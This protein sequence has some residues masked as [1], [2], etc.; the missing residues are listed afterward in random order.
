MERRN[1][2]CHAHFGREDRLF[3]YWIV[4]MAEQKFELGLFCPVD[5]YPDKDP[6][7]AVAQRI[8]ETVKIAMI[9]D[10]LQFDEM[11]IAEGHFGLATGVCTN[12]HILL[13]HLF[14]TT[15]NLKL[16]PGVSVLPLHDSIL[17][18]ESFALL[19]SLAGDRLLVGVG[20]GFHKPTFRRLGIPFEERHE[21]FE[22]NLGRLMLALAAAGS[23]VVASAPAAFQDRLWASAASPESMEALSAKGLGLL[24]SPAISMLTESEL[25][26]ILARFDRQG[27]AEDP[28]VGTVV[29]VV[30]DENGDR[31]HDSGMQALNKRTQALAEA[32]EDTK[33]ARHITMSTRFATR[34]GHVIFGA[35]E[36]AAAQIDR[37]RNLGVR[38]LLAMVDFGDIGVSAALNTIQH[39]ARIHPNPEYRETHHG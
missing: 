21:L 24:I 34:N 5:C 14:A 25:G 7:A 29:H 22:R 3:G 11:W 15:E 8:E 39:L 1:W 20:S 36:D 13:A 10:S 37:L 12:P 30:I 23:D 18:A 26:Q 32:A 28:R 27:A 19:D 6:K 38:K 16:G 4:S 33:A 31:A 17:L 2:C 9:A 35:P